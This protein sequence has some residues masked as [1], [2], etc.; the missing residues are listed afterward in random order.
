MCATCGKPIE[1]DEDG[2]CLAYDLLHF[3]PGH[4]AYL[5]R[6]AKC[7]AEHQKAKNRGEM[8]D[9]TLILNE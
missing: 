6:C 8:D 3:T 9:V 4:A 5:F 2:E 7:V 1:I